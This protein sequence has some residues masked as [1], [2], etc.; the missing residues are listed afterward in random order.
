MKP[1]G[2]NTSDVIYPDGTIVVDNVPSELVQY[3]RR[4]NNADDTLN[5]YV[6]NATVCDISEELIGKIDIDT[7]NRTTFIPVLKSASTSFSPMFYDDTMIKLCTTYVTTDGRITSRQNGTAFR[8]L[9]STY[10]VEDDVYYHGYRIDGI[11]NSKFVDEL[12]NRDAYMKTSGND[13]PTIGTISMS[14]SPLHIA[15]VEYILRVNDDAIERSYLY[16][17]SE[18]YT[19]RT[20][21]QYNPY[22]LMLDAIMDDTYSVSDSHFDHDVLKEMWVDSELIHNAWD[23]T[24]DKKVPLYVYHD[25]PVTVGTDR[26]LIVRPCSEIPQIEDGYRVKWRWISYGI[27]DKTN[28]K[29]NNG[30]MSRILLFESSNRVISVTPAMLGSQSVELYCMDKYGNVISNTGGGNI[31]VDSEQYTEKVHVLV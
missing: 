29:D 18:F 6:I 16:G 27:E 30:N 20:S 8:V 23:D 1:T 2:R 14:I 28:W 9:E 7:E 12:K 21:V 26:Y 3:V 25:T 24:D 4:I 19:M 17:D 10:I 5:L 15:P 22:Q 13:V 31:M 11:V